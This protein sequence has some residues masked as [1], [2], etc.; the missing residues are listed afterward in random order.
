MAANVIAFI[1]LVAQAYSGQLKLPAFQRDWKWKRS[2]V[3]LLY[4]SLRQG[5]PIGSFLFLKKGKDVALSP[6]DFTNVAWLNLDP[7]VQLQ[8]AFGVRGEA[9][10]RE[11]LKAHLVSDDCI[12]VLM[13]PNKTLGDF[14]EFI[15]KREAAFA[16]ALSTWGFK[17]PALGQEQMED[18]EDD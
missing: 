11:R 8:N 13:R 10:V 3:I 12:D 1:D 6:R 14:E 9:V 2:Q 15:M 17:K 4:D 5:F 16:A 7:S 18:E